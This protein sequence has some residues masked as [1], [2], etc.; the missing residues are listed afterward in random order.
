MN[1]EPSLTDPISPAWQKFFSAFDEIDVIPIEN[2]KPVHLISY[3]CRLY[4]K[5]YGVK[6]TFKFK[7]IPSKSYECYRTRELAQNISSNPVI[8]KDYIDWFFVEKIIEKKRRI[9][10]MA[11]LTDTNVV[12]EYKFKK[13]LMGQSAAIDRAT[14]IPPNYIITIKKYGF[15]FTTY[16][17]LSFVKM[18]LDA[19]NGNQNHKDMLVELGK[20]GMDISMLDRVK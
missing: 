1:K 12:N 7:S 16:G 3:W 11:F 4:E 10:S 5:Q 9:T 15:N 20:D 19:G 8:L 17:E 6:Y 13:L 2:W 14:I 18:Y